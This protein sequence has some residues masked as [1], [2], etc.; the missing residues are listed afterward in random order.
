MG[1]TTGTGKGTQ[2]KEQG[3]GKGLENSGESIGKQEKE[4]GNSKNADSS[5]N[6]GVAGTTEPN[7]ETQTA[8]EIPGRE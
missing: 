4:N 8:K 5:S 6:N 3:K 7:Q 1:P 2:S